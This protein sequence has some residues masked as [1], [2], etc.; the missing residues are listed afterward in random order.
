[1]V[2]TISG[3]PTT[4]ESYAYDKVGNRTSSLNIPSYTV[5]SSNQLTST[6]NGTYTYDNNGNTLTD[7]SKNATY[8][9]DME[10]RL[11]QVSFTGGGTVTYKYDPFGRRIYRSGPSGTTIWLYDS[12][13]IVEELDSS[14][15]VQAEYTQGSG[16]DEPLAMLRGASSHYYEADGLGSVTSLTDSGGTVGETYKYDAYGNLTSGGTTLNNPF[17]YTAREWDADAGMYYYRARYYHPILSRF[18][19]EDHTRF[20]ADSNFYRYVANNPVNLVD[21]SGLRPKDPFQWRYCSGSE[22]AI[23]RATCAARGQVYQSCRVVRVFRFGPRGL[24]VGPEWI[25]GRMSCACRD[26]NEC[27]QASKAT[28][29]ASAQFKQFLIGLG[30]IGAAGG[31]ALAPELLPALPPIVDQLKPVLEQLGATG[32][33]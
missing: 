8:T 4:T 25:D 32:A 13:N 30:I 29:E 26:K 5:N 19:S 18:L 28:A 24:S 16:I 17:R 2:Q 27:H 10:N 31:A 22:I 15:A 7:S 3:T 20:K 6:T 12:A 1:V 11:A 14:G 23:C 33:H 9:W 21:P